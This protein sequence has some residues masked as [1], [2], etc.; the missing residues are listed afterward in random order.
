MFELCFTNKSVLSINQNVDGPGQ[1]E[2]KTQL[3]QRY[4]HEKKCA[5]SKNFYNQRE[6]AEIL[7][8]DQESL[9]SG[10]GINDQ[11][12]RYAT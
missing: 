5:C 3:K 9:F 7:I 12:K 6:I 10:Q 4:H 1:E 2:G 8:F 11:L